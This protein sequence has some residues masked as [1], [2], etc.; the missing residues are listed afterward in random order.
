MTNCDPT[1]TL[2]ALTADRRALH[3]RPE[4]G[5]TEFE[6]TWFI[7]Q[8]LEA[9][10]IPYRAGIANVDPANVP[11]RDPKKVE[12]ALKRARE[13][14]PAEFLDML[15]G[16][17]GVVAEIDTGREGPLTA[18][19]FDIDC[20]CV[21]ESTSCGHIPAR[22]GFASECPGLMHACG[23]DAH[24]AVGL[25]VA[26][27]VAHH[28]DEL[29]GRIRLIFQP[30][31]EGTRGAVAM[32]AKGIVDDVDY[33]LGSHVG[34]DAKAGEVLVMKGGFLATSKIN[35]RFTGTPS[36]AG[37]KPEDGRSALLAAA[38]AALQ[39]SGISRHSQGASRVSVGAPNAGEGRNV[40]PVHAR[41]QVETRG[42]TDAINEFLE[43][44]IRRIVEGESIVYD[45]K[46][47]MEVVGK[48]ATL[49]VC[50]AF[51]DRVLETAKGVDGVKS[52]TFWAKPLASED[53]TIFMQRVVARGGEA[54]FFVWGSE[55]N[56]HHKTD[57][58][59]RPE[60]MEVGLGVFRAMLKNL[61]GCGKH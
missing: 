18:L 33:F 56:G 28:R 52:A 35:I 9:L 44:N 20:V 6:T 4:E 5:W 39:I 45:V 48:G 17:T 58:D 41:L 40:T 19:R 24:T 8:R 32:A 54:A 55:N 36:H 3:R 27:W 16:Y 49:P 34:C 30:A 42:E 53:C 38:S 15:G 31:E 2:E 23:H 59:V 26:A 7:A 37:A 1:Q 61:N 12:A 57:F 25:A 22:E 46:G 10:G 29:T 43:A 50:D 60:A 51:C 13:R 21:E 11:G 14:V 47:E